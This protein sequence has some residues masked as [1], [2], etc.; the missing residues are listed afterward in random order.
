MKKILILSAIVVFSAACQNK[1]E[2]TINGSVADK[3][4]EGQQIYLEK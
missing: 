2:Y 3:T 1:S 4:Y